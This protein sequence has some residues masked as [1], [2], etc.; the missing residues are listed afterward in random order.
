[1]PTQAPV[2]FE[3]KHK[4]KP[5]GKVF[6]SFS[7]KAVPAG[8]FAGMLHVTV[9]KIDEFSDT[10]GLMRRRTDPYVLL[11]LSS[12]KQKTSNKKNVC[13]RLIFLL[14]TISNCLYYVPL[15]GRSTRMQCT[16][17][18]CDELLYFC[19]TLHQKVNYFRFFASNEA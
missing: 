5:A 3:C 8:A 17:I 9:H 11:H 15:S 10:L 1:M 14:C 2:A 19:F 7:R 6:L 16:F 13:P 12:V 4:G 18:Y